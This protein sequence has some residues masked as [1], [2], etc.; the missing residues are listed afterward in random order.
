MSS[1]NRANADVEL[2]NV[3]FRKL[4]GTPAPH[5]LTGPRMTSTRADEI[6][7]SVPTW[8]WRWLARGALHIL[9]GRQGGGESTFAAW[10]TAQVTTGRPYPDDPK[11]HEPSNVATLSFEEA[12]DRLVARLHAAGRPWRLI[13]QLR[14][15]RHWNH[16][17]QHY[18]TNG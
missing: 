15:V 13:R 3:E 2:G 18:R 8:L 5:D 16:G 6:M 7:P 12:D 17:S 10:L 1:T 14:A 9:V 11:F 4:M